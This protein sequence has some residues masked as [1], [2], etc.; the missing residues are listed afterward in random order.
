MAGTVHTPSQI[1]SADSYD[2]L[3]RK[4]RRGPLNAPDAPTLPQLGTLGMSCLPDFNTQGLV[5]AK[6]SLFRT[7]PLLSTAKQRP[8]VPQHLAISVRTPRCLHGLALG[9]Y[10]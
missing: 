7:Q 2:E 6:A 8:V 1:L 3:Q 5:T 9:D 10:K 4:S